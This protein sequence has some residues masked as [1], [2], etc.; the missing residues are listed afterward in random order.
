MQRPSRAVF[1]RPRGRR[2]NRAM[3][4]RSVIPGLVAAVVA[5]GC[6]TRTP[7]PLVAVGVVAPGLDAFLAAHPPAEGQAIR[8]DR[9]AES[10]AASWYV[11]QARGPESPHRHRTHDLTVVVLRGTGTLTLGEA[12]HRMAPGDVA[13]VP[14]DVPHW[15]AP[16]AGTTA[17]ALT[18]FTPALD[19]PDVDPVAPRAPA[20]DTQGGRQ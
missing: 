6:A 11:V 8:V 10:A 1:E 17:V 12:R 5:V 15:F 2:Q 3:R 20:V 7:T 13:L 19:A 18:T 4:M 14:R 9:V 16:D